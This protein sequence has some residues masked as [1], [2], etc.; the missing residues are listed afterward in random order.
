MTGAFDYLARAFGA[1]YID[2]NEKDG[3]ITIG[4]IKTDAFFNDI[5]H[6]WGSSRIAKH[7]FNDVRPTRLVFYSFFAVDMLYMFQQIVELKQRQSSKYRL[8]KAIE[9]LQTE[10]WLRSMKEP[11]ADII[12]LTVL[13]DLK[14]TLF[15]P[16]IDFLKIYNEKVPKM[17]V[18]GFL[19]AADPGC[20]TGD[21]VVSFS[22]NGVSFEMPIAEARQRFNQL[23]NRR[24]NWDL[25]TLTYVRSYLGDSIGLNPIRGIAES[26]IQTVYLVDLENG[27]SLKCTHDHPILT[28][29]GWIKT[30]FIINE[31]VM[32]DGQS[33][34]E[35]HR[36]IRLTCLGTEQTYDICC[37]E[38][39]HSYVA[40]GMVVS[41]TGKTLMSIAAAHCLHSEVE[42]VISPMNAVDDAWVGGYY[43]E[44]GNDA[45]VWASTHTAPLTDGYQRYIF[46]YAALDRAIELARR[47]SHKKITIILDES[48]NFNDIGSTRTKQFIHLCYVSKSENIMFLSGTPVKALGLEMITLFYAID[49]LFNAEVAA[50]FKLIYGMS[51]KRANDILRNRL[52]LVSIKIPKSL[53]MKLPEPEVI[54]VKIRITKPERFYITTIQN[55]LKKF[56]EERYAF[57]KKNMSR[58]EQI[59]QQGLVAFEKT[60]QSRQESLDLRTYKE[61]VAIIRKGYDVAAHAELAKFCSMFEKTKILPRL[62]S[63]MRKPF[64]DAITVVKFVKLKILGEALGNV[65]GKARA[66]CH[67]EMING[68]CYVKNKFFGH[69]ERIVYEADKKTL[70]FTSFVPALKESIEYFS[71]MGLNCR[72]V[73]ADTNKDLVKI[74][75][76]YKTDPTVNPLLATYQSLQAS[77]T[78]ICASAVILL[79]LP[80]REYIRTQA[81]NRIYRIGQDTICVIYECTLDTGNIPNIS[82]RS[83][84][85]MRWSEEQVN[86]IM[87]KEVKGGEGI[88]KYLHLNPHAPMD[89]FINFF[90]DLFD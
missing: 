20:V 16:Q 84:D 83:E 22:R 19:I 65:Y 60:I 9:Y 68:E 12:D 66:E 27:L 15:P 49:P 59:Y 31:M 86:M 58:Y 18:K 21:T 78:L 56:M 37:Y 30:Q 63:A 67:I 23:G 2:E 10:T 17:Q 51:A 41:N 79:D 6:V 77:V 80:F 40:N 33:G 48:H 25:D 62:P 81:V 85:I 46:H 90:K 44:Y 76:S 1:V 35:Y 87:G 13:S 52:D 73:Y 39:H 88:V 26:G 3:L 24:E 47:L 89:R 64:K 69:L 74:I 5:N 4:G 45:S 14:H 8:Q 57:Y 53:V 71:G 11:H 42:I 28:E 55:N 61:Y 50:R 70:L 7:M 75:H 43:S 38:P 82:T 72:A 54:Q 36:A 32:C 34:P 29:C